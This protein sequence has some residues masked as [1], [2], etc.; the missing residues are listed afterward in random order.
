MAYQPP[1]VDQRTADQLRYYLNQIRRSS[2]INSLKQPPFR[3]RQQIFKLADE[4]DET[5]RDLNARERR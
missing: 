5:L 2:R 4:A 1:P 3:I